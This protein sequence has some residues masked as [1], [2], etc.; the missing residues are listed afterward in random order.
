[1]MRLGA[2]P[3]S[4]AVPP[5]LAAYG[6]H[7]K[8]PFHTFSWYSDSDRISSAVLVVSKSPNR[9]SR[10]ALAIGSIMAVVAVL[11]SHMD[12]K[13]EINQHYAYWSGA[14]RVSVT[15]YAGVVLRTSYEQ[16]E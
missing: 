8:N 13:D 2:V 4:V 6:I 14:E 1:M 5:I 12:R 3:V 9:L 11:L 10:M 15:T 16:L 7:I